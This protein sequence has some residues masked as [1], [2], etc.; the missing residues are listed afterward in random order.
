MKLFFRF[1]V[2]T[3]VLT[4]CT[5]QPILKR[6]WNMHDGYDMLW[7]LL[8]RE[9][10]E[11][12]YLMAEVEIKWKVDNRVDRASALLQVAGPDRIGL[13]IRGPLYSHLLSVFVQVD[14]LIVF[15][16]TV[17][18]PLKG[19]INGPLLSNITG[20]HLGNN[21]FSSLLLGKVILDDRKLISERYLRADRALLTYENEVSRQ[22]FTLDLFSGV[23]LGERFERP[24]G[25]VLFERKMKNY[26]KVDDFFLP[27][28]VKIVQD[29]VIIELT[30][31][32]FETTKVL[33]FDRF[34]PGI[35]DAEILRVLYP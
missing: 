9:T 31:K 14:S 11:L 23:I 26:V 12:N 3:V 7:A 28:N 20:L 25:E 15:G 19:A 27:R 30:F 6:S 8:D 18:K 4:A 2:I 10:T 32:S 22:V 35:P 17:G 1:I 21:H 16:K 34:D 29:E 33:S 5:G 24:I 13:E